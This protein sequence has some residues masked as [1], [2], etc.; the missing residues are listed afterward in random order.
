MNQ[1]LVG[2]GVTL[3]LV[4]LALRSFAAQ[5]QMAKLAARCPTQACCPKDNCEAFPVEEAYSQ[6]ARP[7]GWN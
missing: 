2:Q 4:W 7:A 5:S 1:G 3:Q 6:A